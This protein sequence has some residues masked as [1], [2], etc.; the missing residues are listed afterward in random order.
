[1]FLKVMYTGTYP[2]ATDDAKPIYARD[3]L[4]SGLTGHSM[5]EIERLLR[6]VSEENF[7]DGF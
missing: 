6:T 2:D 3:P 1:M 7:V 5:A 4:P